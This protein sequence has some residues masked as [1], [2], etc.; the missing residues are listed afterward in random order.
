MHSLTK[1][2]LRELYFQYGENALR[3]LG[4]IRSIRSEVLQPG[5]KITDEIGDVRD[6]DDPILNSWYVC[7]QCS[8]AFHHSAIVMKP[9][10]LT[11]EHVPPESVG[12]NTLVLT[13][14]ECNEKA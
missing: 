3:E 14:K 6:L 8:R 11:L 1:D 13:C 10:A 4:W 5:V 9:P 2:E 7:P 12:G